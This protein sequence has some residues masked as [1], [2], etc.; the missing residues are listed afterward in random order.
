MATATDSAL[1]ATRDSQAIPAALVSEV[2][3]VTDS[4]VCVAA[5]TAYANA[6]RNDTLTGGRVPQPGDSALGSAVY[7]VLVKDRYVVVD[8]ANI[9]GEF[10][11]A[12]VFDSAFLTP[13][14]RLGM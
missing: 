3:L 9:A 6:E 12:W 14:K 13:L 10:Q 11:I 4:A 8:A 7:V 1:I 2:A 5:G